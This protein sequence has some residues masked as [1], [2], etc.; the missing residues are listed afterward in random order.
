M[1]TDE[2][3]KKATP[4]SASKKCMFLR[5]LVVELTSSFI[6]L[7]LLI[8]LIVGG[9]AIA[10][11]CIGIG[12]SL[13]KEVLQFFSSNLINPTFNLIYATIVTGR[14]CYRW[15]KNTTTNAEG[16]KANHG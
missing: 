3:L 10:G 5:G 2:I 13:G 1:K 15:R 8:S 4:S 14:F 7:F 11:A 16:G 6:L 12:C 9:F